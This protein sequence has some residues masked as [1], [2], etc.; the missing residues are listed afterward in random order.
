[1]HSARTRIL[2]IEDSQ[3]VR[4]LLTL[5]LE[6]EGFSVAA[7]HDS[8]TA[9]GSIK[10]QRPDLILT[11]IMLGAGSGLDLISRVRGELSPPIPPIIACSGFTGFA[12]EALKRGAAAF[13]PK[14][15]HASTL[16]QTV[17]AV[18]DHRKLEQQER[19]EA[20]ARARA[21]RA[22]AVEAAQ[23][24]LA[25]LGISDREAVLRAYWTTEFLPRYLGFGQAFMTVLEGDEMKVSASSHEQTWQRGQRV[26]L[27]LCRDIVETG[28]ALVIPDLRSLGVSLAAP[29]GNDVRFFAGVPVANRATPIGSLCLVDG[30]PRRLSSDDFSILEGFGAQA[31]AALSARASAPIWEGSGLFSRDGLSM[32]LRAELSRL[33]R[34]ALSFDL[35]VF[36]GS[37]EGGIMWQRTAL[38][39]LGE[40]RF[41]AAFTRDDA[42][43]S[44]RALLAFVA[45][46]AQTRSF[47]GGGAVSIQGG[48]E[49]SFDAGAVVSLAEGLF[50]SAARAGPET[51]E[52]IVIR[53]E[54]LPVEMAG[55]K[56]H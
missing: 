56:E 50:E 18:M 14:P 48:P 51:V 29:D 44:H 33:R 43:D 8:E 53:R 12:D 3:D 9:F 6:N 30:D 36:G 10:E 20:G 17:A 16:L 2:V 39:K 4:E 23:H 52:R 40:R 5:L 22:K 49:A 41:A 32:L 13:I 42:A 34:D 31:S 24:A 21:L 37:C 47:T 45:E 19:D 38:A 28:S 11:D 55:W 15:L 1:M 46:V 25:A 54:P 26:E 7:C 35:L 27:A